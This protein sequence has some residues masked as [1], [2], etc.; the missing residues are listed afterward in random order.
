MSDKMKRRIP[1]PN[2]VEKVYIPEKNKKKK[3]RLKCDYKC[4]ICNKRICDEQI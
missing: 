3:F 4:D 2:Q 1:L